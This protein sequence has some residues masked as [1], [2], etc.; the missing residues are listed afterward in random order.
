[1]ARYSLRN[2][3]KIKIAKGQNTLDIVVKS[4]NKHFEDH[5]TIE[6]APDLKDHTGYEVIVIDVLNLSND[7]KIAKNT[8][9]AFYVISNTYDVYN[10]AL[11]EFIK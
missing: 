2:Q 10:L 11:K 5:D 6:I 7:T 4:L 3:H 1:M 8:K 9:I